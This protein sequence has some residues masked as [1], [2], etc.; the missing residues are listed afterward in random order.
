MNI[1]LK[2]ILFFNL[3]QLQ[4]CHF[5][6]LPQGHPRWLS[7]KETT[8][9]AGDVGL[10]PELGRSPREGNCNAHQ[11]F[12]LKIPWTGEPGGLQ[13]VG[14]Q[15]VGNDLATKQQHPAPSK[16]PSP[17]LTLAWPRW[18]FPFNS[19]F[20]TSLMT[21]CYTGSW[22]NCRYQARSLCLFLLSNAERNDS[23]TKMVVFWTC[24]L[25]LSNI[26]MLD[27]AFT[28]AFN[29]EVFPRMFGIMEMLV[30]IT[31]PK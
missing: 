2:K 26:W 4:S 17:F 20:D 5:C 16:A 13:S 22:S 30:L 9:H 25:I 21:G 8:C 11:S 3:C 7:G 24:V 27:A 23:Q 12:S 29:F 28:H 31:S 10:I 18:N 14:L 1:F 15:R 6:I 19:I